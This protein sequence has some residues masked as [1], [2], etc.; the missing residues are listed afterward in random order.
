MIGF[1][2]V[3]GAVVGGLGPS[4]IG[5]LEPAAGLGEW[6][7]S[8]GRIAWVT[9]AYRLTITH[10]LDPSPSP[11]PQVGCEF[12]PDR[13]PLLG[14]SLSFGWAEAIEHAELLGLGEWY[15]VQIRCWV[16]GSPTLI[17][18]FRRFF[19]PPQ[20]PSPPAPDVV[21][22]PR[23]EIYAQRALQFESAA[24]GLSPPAQQFVGGADLAR[25]DERARVRADHGKCRPALGDG[26]VRVP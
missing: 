1:G 6:A 23:L 7:E 16:A 18:G 3:V 8:D 20:P 5:G 2:L 9:A 17:P 14:D 22:K 24:V 26:T 13:G 10:T 11:G 21:E 19:D 25:R 15:S 12:F 4:S